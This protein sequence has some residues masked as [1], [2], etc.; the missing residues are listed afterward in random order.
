MTGL[1]VLM[2]G[3]CITRET[4]TEKYIGRCSSKLFKMTDLLVEVTD[5]NA[6]VLE[7]HFVRQRIFTNLPFIR[8]NLMKEDILFLRSLIKIW[9][10]EPFQSDSDAP[11]TELPK[12]WIK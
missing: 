10:S 2:G 6:I 5:E 8:I 4:K 9:Q 11:P 12:A 3:I 7:G 1:N